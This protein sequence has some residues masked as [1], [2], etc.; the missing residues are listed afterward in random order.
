MKSF[1]IFLAENEYYYHGTKSSNK[2]EIGKNGLQVSKSLFG[3]NLFLTR[4]H[5]EAQKYSKHKG[6]LGVVYKIHIN[7]L[8]S[9]FLDSK[10]G[11]LQYT[12]D[13]PK[14]HLELVE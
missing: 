9:K 10:N 6:K 7:K 2:D 12:K 5:Y 11:V 1:Q 13:I 8:D 4:R 14:E 3:K